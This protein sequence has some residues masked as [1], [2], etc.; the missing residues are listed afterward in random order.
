LP[1]WRFAATSA[2]IFTRLTFGYMKAKIY[3]SALLL[4]VGFFIA[5]ASTDR[6]DWAFKTPAELFN[7][8]IHESALEMM[9][10]IREFDPTE[11]TVAVA[12]FVDLDKVEET[13]SFGRYVAERM[14]Q[15]LHKLGFKTLELR[16]RKDIEIIHDKGEF[17]LSRRSSELLKKSKIG[18]VAVGSYMLVGDEVV[19]NARLLGVD[20]G[21]VLSVSQIVAS[22]SGDSAVGA[23]L[24]P[25]FEKSK[26]ENTR[27]V[28][29]ARAMD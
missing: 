23:L 5:C 14:G 25:K 19:V 3:G 10:G 1:E 6:S 17:I 8:K 27:P 21:S 18:A 16:Q 12:S 29:K 28:V 15:E 24:R 13:S 11:K 20:T 2:G 22:V 7:N 26:P 4:A 9:G